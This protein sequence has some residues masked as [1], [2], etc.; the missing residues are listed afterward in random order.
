MKK[1]LL[2]FKDEVA[3]AVAAGDQEQVTNVYRRQIAWFKCGADVSG[4]SAD[5]LESALKAAEADPGKMKRNLLVEILAVQSMLLHR[6]REELM[7]RIRKHDEKPNGFDPWGNLPPEISA[8][9]LPRYA[10]LTSEVFHTL[11]VMQ[12]LECQPADPD[13]KADIA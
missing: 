5:V 13:E 9:L 12:K 3:A 4:Y 7:A 8:E 1:K 11:K 10:R 2:G 6:V